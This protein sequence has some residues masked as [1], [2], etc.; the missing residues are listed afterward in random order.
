MIE[1][2]GGL[3]FILQ[4]TGIID[5][6]DDPKTNSINLGFE[7]KPTNPKITT[8][9]VDAIVNDDGSSTPVLSIKEK[10]IPDKKVTDLTS[11]DNSD[12]QNAVFPDQKPRIIDSPKSLIFL[13][14]TKN[15]DFPA[16]T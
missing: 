16:E 2:L 10:I 12:E 11:K 6:W 14:I 8:H 3:Y 9:L 7:T 4:F 13:M 15:V 1:I 5:V